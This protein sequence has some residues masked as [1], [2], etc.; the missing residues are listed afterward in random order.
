MTREID[1]STGYI[2]LGR[3]MTYSLEPGWE[4]GLQRLVP[5]HLHDGLLNYLFDGIEPGRFLCA[6]LDNDLSGAVVRAD[7]ESLAGLRGLVT[8]LNMYVPRPAWPGCRKSWCEMH[9]QTQFDEDVDNVRA[10]GAQRREFTTVATV[11]GRWSSS[12]PN[13]QDLPRNDR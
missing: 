7:A 11:T 1:R 3:G 5:P 6:V 10:W 2:R 9:A 13:L 8:W 12:M 4:N